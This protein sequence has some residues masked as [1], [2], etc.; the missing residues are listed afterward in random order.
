MAVV[1]AADA[2]AATVAV[3]G[4]NRTRGRHASAVL[5]MRDEWVDAPGA[6]P[7]DGLCRDAV[8][9]KRVV[10]PRDRPSQTQRRG[11]SYSVT[12]ILV[13]GP[14]RMCTTT[15]VEAVKSPRGVGSIRRMCP[16]QLGHS[17][18]SRGASTP[19]TEVDLRRPAHAPLLA[20]PIVTSQ[21]RHSG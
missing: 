18:S 6:V 17:S 12:V 15:S 16:A 20:R 7:S 21:P 9:S 13:R 3:P 10:M 1:R 8:G 5:V 14:A 2:P 4:L 19:Q 11:G